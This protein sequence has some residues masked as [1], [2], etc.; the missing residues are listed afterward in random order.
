MSSNNPAHANLESP[1]RAAVSSGSESAAE[2]SLTTPPLPSAIK[3]NSRSVSRGP[4]LSQAVPFLGALDLSGTA[5]HVVR[6][7]G[8]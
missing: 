4:R 3:N 5:I 7:S 6:W 1:A 8:T 2:R